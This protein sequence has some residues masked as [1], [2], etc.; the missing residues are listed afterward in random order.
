MFKC[1]GEEDCPR[2][3][4][5]ISCGWLLLIYLNIIHED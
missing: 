1:D 2:G 5:E 4:D 3:E